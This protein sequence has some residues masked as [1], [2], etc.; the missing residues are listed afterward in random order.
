MAILAI[1]AGVSCENEV[2]INAP[3]KDIT[4]AYGVLDG[5]DTNHFLKVNK[6]FLTQGN[7][8]TYAKEEYSN[9]YYE[10]LSV[11]IEE[12]GPE[13]ASLRTFTLKDT[14]VNKEEGLFE[15]DE[16]QTLYHFKAPDLD[17]ANSYTLRILIDEGEKSEKLVKGSTD[18]VGEVEL[19]SHNPGTQFGDDLFFYS[20]GEYRKEELEWTQITNATEVILT[21]RFHYSNIF[22]N[23]DTVQHSF[24]WKV[25]TKEGDATSLQVGGENFYRRIDNVLSPNPSGLKEREMDRIDLLVTAADQELRT[26]TSVAGPSSSIVQERPDYTNLDTAAVGIFASTRKVQL[27]GLSLSG[28]SMDQLIEGD[29]TGPLNFVN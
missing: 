15:H 22:D 11:T 7:A 10:D 12:M 5:G 16:A 13:G 17:P 9:T 25:G 2:R 26:Y 3:K 24:D 18:L 4:V 6:G 28:T 8:R 27:K 21:L 19:T 29:I 1:L 14:M 23:G 20:G